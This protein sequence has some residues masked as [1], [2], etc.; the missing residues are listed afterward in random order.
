MAKVNPKVQ[1]RQT[2]HWAIGDRDWAPLYNTTILEQ[3]GCVNKQ[4]VFEKLGK[5]EPF[6]HQ[7]LKSP[8][9]QT[10]AYREKYPKEFFPI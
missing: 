4:I 9:T 2:Q 1:Y 3:T 10:D 8:S 6:S 7:I 5:I